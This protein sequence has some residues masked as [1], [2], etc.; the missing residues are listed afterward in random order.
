MDVPDSLTLRPQW[1]TWRIVEDQ[2]RPNCRWQ[3]RGNWCE[4]HEVS[5]FE[6]IG[7]VF[8]ADDPLCGIDL[9]DCIHEGGDWSDWAIE[10]MERFAGVA[11]AEISPS[12]TGVKLWTLGKKR[13]GFKCTS[14]NGVECYD[15]GRWFAVTGKRVDG[16]ETIGDGQEPLDWL[17]EKY[18]KVAVKESL[19]TAGPQVCF[20]LT[21]LM[22]RARKYVSNAERPSEGGRN[23][24]AFRLAGHLYAMVQPDG[25]RLTEMEIL[26]LVNG[27]NHSLPNPLGDRE[28]EAVVASAGKSGT[29]RQDKEPTLRVEQDLGVDISK[30]INQ[31]WATKQQELADEDN[32]TDEAFCEA[33]V[34]ES[35]LLRQV[36]DFYC[37]TA[38]RKSNVMGLAV[39]VSL[40]ETLFG[41]RICS[42]TDMRTNDYN[43]ILATTGSGKEACEATIT[44]ILDAADPN[45]THQLPPDIQSGN[46][47]MKAISVNPCGIWVCDEFGKILQS[48]LDKKGNQHIKNIGTHLLKVYSKSNGVYGGAGHSDGIRNRV[49]EPHLVLLGLSTGST[50]FAA[51]SSDQVSDGLLGRIA[52]WPVQDRPVPSRNF[53]KVS[54]GEELVERVKAWIAFA[55]GGN[56]GAQFPRAETIRFSADAE[57]RWD[58]HGV[59]IDDRMRAESDARAAVWAR[60]AARSMKLALVHRAA[61]LEVDP[62]SCA[63]E[64]VQ[65]E[66]QDVNWGIKL[67]N[68]LA[69]IAC[70]LIQENTV[71]RGLDKAKMVLT[72]A[73]K[74]GPARSR[75]LLR[76]CRSIT[77]GDLAAAA[78]A[79]GYLVEEIPTRSKGNKAKIYRRPDS[80]LAVP[81]SVG[82][83][84]Q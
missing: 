56:L 17:C 49:R 18:L 3:D 70:D 12:G 20:S 72:E 65:L 33:M 27:W 21:S 59:Q 26:A 25:E 57:K 40:C 13:D 60:V 73:T 31:Q 30:I 77:A 24:A 32:D 44:K 81:T 19:P 2:K 39:A 80:V 75:D 10:I 7:F 55:P 58:V 28:I 6:K 35:G 61:R 42:Q 79:L 14:G 47:L 67:S 68:W 46:G 5:D 16:Y 34:P 54:P 1:I 63:F 84:S 8:T 69:R 45:G 66:L 51:V 37:R 23:N 48:V 62:G 71:D 50:V 52:F 22:D 82:K 64:F 74:Y 41:R 29:P 9:D 76:A 36:F 15:R 11:Y 53:E 4:F 83:E 43:L 78:V 38:Y